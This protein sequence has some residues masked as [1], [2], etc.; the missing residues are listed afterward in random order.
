MK[1]TILWVLAGVNAVLLGTFLSHYVRENTAEAQAQVA[2][3]GPGE[4]L[5]CPGAITGLSTEVVY[6]IDTLHGQMGAFV[7][8]TNGRRLDTMAGVDL[9]RVFQAGVGPQGG[10]VPGVPGTIPPGVQGVQRR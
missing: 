9:N 7:Y 1:T 10:V 6:V 8:D 3:G 4:Y 2:A 5:L